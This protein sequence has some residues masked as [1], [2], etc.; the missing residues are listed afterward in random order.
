MHPSEVLGHFVLL[1][2]ESAALD[3]LT[4]EAAYPP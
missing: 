4:F 3:L 2:E 1:G